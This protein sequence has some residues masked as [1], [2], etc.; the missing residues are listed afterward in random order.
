MATL[1]NAVCLYLPFNGKDGDTSTIDYSKGGHSV[2]FNG[3]ASIQKEK[4]YERV[5][6]CYF[7]GTGDY[8]SL[9][10]SADW[11]LGT[12]FTLKAKIYLNSISTDQGIIAHYEAGGSGGWVFL[13]DTLA[14][15]RFYDYT[16]SFNINI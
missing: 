7:D 4:Y 9:A 3:G 8:L 10:D 11:D 13:W 1:S 6:S 12:T 15:L 16:G 14:G 2:T 5:S